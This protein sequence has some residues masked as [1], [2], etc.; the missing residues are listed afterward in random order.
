M[1]DAEVADEAGDKAPWYARLPVQK[2]ENDFKDMLQGMS[3]NG[4]MQQPTALRLCM[5]V[6]VAFIH[7]LA[8]TVY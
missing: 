6:D 2:P 5:N 4:P 8:S 7:L 3:S 1:P